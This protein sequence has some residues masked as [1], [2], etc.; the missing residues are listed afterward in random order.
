M[1][2]TFVKDIDIAQRYGV[3]RNTV[4]RWARELEGMPAPVRLSP[5]CTRWRMSDLEAWEREL[6]EAAQ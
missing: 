4:W 6:A 5:C 2:E 3:S 1:P